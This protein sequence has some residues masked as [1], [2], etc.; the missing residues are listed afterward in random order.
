MNCGLSELV[1]LCPN[2][3]GSAKP[4]SAATE[5]FGDSQQGH[6]QSWY[7]SVPAVK[8]ELYQKG[9]VLKTRK[10]TKRNKTNTKASWIWS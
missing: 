4:G 2:K 9:R 6:V 3:S 10:K 5:E 7:L 8:S 1:K